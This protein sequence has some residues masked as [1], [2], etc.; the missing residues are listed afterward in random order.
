[1]R[2]GMR[3]NTIYSNSFPK[4]YSSSHHHG[5]V[6][7]TK[8]SEISLFICTG[9]LSHQLL[10][11]QA[12]HLLRMFKRQHNHENRWYLPRAKI[13]DRASALG[14]DKPSPLL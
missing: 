6:L 11:Y 5:I 4:L 2:S 12:R 10:D 14:E 9:I 3:L 7:M 13:S 1:M 8:L